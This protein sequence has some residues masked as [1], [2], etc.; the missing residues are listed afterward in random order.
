MSM[1]VNSS[2]QAITMESLGISGELTATVIGEMTKRPTRHDI[3]IGVDGFVAPIS[4]SADVTVTSRE[5]CREVER[6]V[7]II[8]FIVRE[9]DEKLE[10]LYQDTVNNEEISKPKSV[11][12]LAHAGND[13]SIERQEKEDDDGRTTVDDDDGRGRI[14][15]GRL[16]ALLTITTREGRGNDFAGRKLVGMIAGVEM[17]LSAL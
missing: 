4:S 12:L 8:L 6:E 3:P 2:D 9:E 1:V 10:R 14:N 11:K 17:M 16:K 7:M 15:V 13:E 5:E